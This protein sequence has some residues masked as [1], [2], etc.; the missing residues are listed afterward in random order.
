[1]GEWY[2]RHSEALHLRL[3]GPAE[4]FDR[5]IREPTVYLLGHQVVDNAEL[6]RFLKDHKVAWETDTEV[7]G[8][9]GAG[10]EN[11]LLRGVPIRG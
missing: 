9:A 4:G 11:A 5:V 3:L 10:R 8:E 7:A 6:D 1:M 2:T